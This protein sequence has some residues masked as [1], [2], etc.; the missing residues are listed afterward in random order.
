MTRNDTSAATGYYWK[1][2]MPADLAPTPGESES[3][4]QDLTKQGQVMDFWY[5]KMLPTA[6]EEC[7][8]VS[9]V[10]QIQGTIDKC[11]PGS[12]WSRYHHLPSES[13]ADLDKVKSTLNTSEGIFQPFRLARITSSSPGTAPSRFPFRPAHAG[14]RSTEIRQKVPGDEYDIEIPGRQPQG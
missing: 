3:D 10:T 1:D 11:K 6:G 8:D 2:F 7:T 13:Y 4:L 5:F 9:C 14:T 12:S